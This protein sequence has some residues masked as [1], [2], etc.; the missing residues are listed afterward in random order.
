VWLLFAR[1]P[2][3]RF[4]VGLVTAVAG[5]AML[6]GGDFRLG[7]KALLGDA[8]GVATA[9]FYAA[10]QLTINRLRA[11]MAT[12]SIMAWSVIFMALPLLALALATGET[13]FPH[14]AA[15]WAKLVGLAVIAQV[16]GQSLIAYAMADL[17]PTFSSVGLL[18]Q[19]VMAT[20]FAWVLL[21]ETLG[22]LAIAGGVVVLVGI[23]IVHRAEVRP[24]DK[25]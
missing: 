13:I 22:W 18:L 6:I 1:R 17:P 10:Y 5:V 20:L 8:L 25:G 24:V 19:P 14:T 9:M 15:G 4:L 23:T 16:A 11:R 3:A 7:G 21:G 12:S 2:S